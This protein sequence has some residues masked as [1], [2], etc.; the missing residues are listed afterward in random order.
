MTEPNP[1]YSRDA[2]AA[3]IRS[4]YD[5]LTHHLPQPNHDNPPIIRDP[6]PTGWPDLD[7]AAL[8]PIGKTANVTDLLRHLPYLAADGAGSDLVG[9]NT[10]AI[11][12]NGPDARWSLDRGVVEGTLEPVG[13]GQ[14]PAHVAVLTQGGRDGSWLLLD[15]ETGEYAFLHFS[16]LWRWKEM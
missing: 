10:R 4:F 11:R 8:A 2:T 7:A 12:Y 5:F 16:S 3:A 15:T 14:V 13:A 6:P 9:P 1:P